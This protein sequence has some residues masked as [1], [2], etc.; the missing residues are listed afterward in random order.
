MLGLQ[1]SCISTF[2]QDNHL[3][4]IGSRNGLYIHPISSLRIIKKLKPQELNKINH[5]YYYPKDM[6]K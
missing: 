1:I 6:Y 2:S 3:T 5:F 4:L